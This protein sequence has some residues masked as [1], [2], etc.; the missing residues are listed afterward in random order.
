MSYSLY[1]SAIDLA[2]DAL[3][4]LSQLLKIAETQPDASSLLSARLHD[5]MLPLTFQVFMVTDISQK[6]AAHATGAEPLTLDASLNSYESMQARI[7]E[8][9]DIVGNVDEKL[10][11]SLED[12]TRTV[13]LDP[14]TKVQ[15]KSRDF[16]NGYALPNVFFHLSMTYAILRKENVSIGKRDYIGSFLGKYLA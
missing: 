2:R 7:E 5:N 11:N 8:V 4:S 14:V 6:I 12:E 13:A 9:L 16:I 3:V 15:M 10:V 1:N